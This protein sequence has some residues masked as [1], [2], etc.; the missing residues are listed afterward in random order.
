MEI[1]PLNSFGLAVIKKEGDLVTD[2]ATGKPYPYDPNQP[3]EVYV[4]RSVPVE[5]EETIHKIIT[6]L[7][8]SYYLRSEIPES[9]KKHG[10]YSKED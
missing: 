5:L 2:P 10:T 8:D 9:W 1:E 3:K 7:V 6:Q 4:E